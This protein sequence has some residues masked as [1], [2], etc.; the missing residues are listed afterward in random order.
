MR[1]ISLNYVYWFPSLEYNSNMPSFRF[2]HPIEIRYGDLDPQGHVNNARY[3]TYMEQARISYLRHL[4][5]WDGGSFLT[6][7]IILANVQ[8]HFLA[9]ILWGRPVHVGVHT[10][11]LGNKSLDMVYTI[12]DQGNET[13]YATG[14]A[15]LVAYDYTRSNTIPIP[16]HWRETILKFEN[17][18]FSD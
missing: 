2:Y 18:D 16:D 13:E 17:I 10:S 7:G 5:L 4:G 12:M 15:V 11:R 9:P 6:L 1:L 8:V 14:S 3:L